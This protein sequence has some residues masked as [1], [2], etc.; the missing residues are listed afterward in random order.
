MCVECEEG[1]EFVEGEVGVKGV[2]CVEG[3][4]Q[5]YCVLMAHLVHSILH[6]LVLNHDPSGVLT[7]LLSRFFCCLVAGLPELGIG[8]SLSHHCLLLPLL[9]LTAGGGRERSMNFQLTMK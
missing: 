2:E 3:E 9:K 7:I 6:P 5:D 4:G 8:Q 1:V